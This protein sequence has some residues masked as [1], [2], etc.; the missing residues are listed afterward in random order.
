MPA[1]ARDE[2]GLAFG[3]ES[4]AAD[5]RLWIRRHI[6]IA[7]SQDVVAFRSGLPGGKDRDPLVGA[8]RGTMIDHAIRNLPR[9]FD[10]HGPRPVGG[11]VIR[12]HDQGIWAVVRLQTLGQPGEAGTEAALLIAH[13][14]DDQKGH[15]SGS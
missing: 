9:G 2:V 15:Q 13:R 11:A 10:R 3:D 5:E 8:I 6:G 4:I 1:G 12:D 7:V 14:N